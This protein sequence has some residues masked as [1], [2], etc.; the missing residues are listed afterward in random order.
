PLPES[1]PESW[2]G[3]PSVFELPPE[4]LR[5]DETGEKR[6]M[7][8]LVAEISA[9]TGVSADVARRAVTIIL[10]FL[11][12]DGPS[13]K[14]QA[15]LDALPG[16]NDAVNAAPPLSGGGIMGVFNDLSAA[17]LGMGEIQNVAGEFVGFARKKIGAEPVDAVV[18]AIPG[19]SQFV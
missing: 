18:G 14:V 3:K 4:R 8:E 19:L 2:D 11:Q 15:L 13:D 12:R 17:G 9:K 1:W 6:V 5:Q 7:D 10:Q 16:A